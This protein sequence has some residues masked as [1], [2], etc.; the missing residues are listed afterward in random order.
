MNAVKDIDM[1][2]FVRENERLVHSVC[3]R[4]VPLLESIRHTT[5]AEYEDLFQVGMIGLMK[6][7]K[8][9]NP[10][11][12]LRMST[13]AVTMIIVTITLSRPHAGLKTI[14]IKSRSWG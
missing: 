12:G 5:G 10:E 7:K 3:Q 8:R 11:L 14:I 13:Y 9:F 2:T 1:D 4:Y 6:A